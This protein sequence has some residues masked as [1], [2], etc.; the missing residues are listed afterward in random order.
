VDPV[1]VGEVVGED[2]MALEVVE[3]RADTWMAVK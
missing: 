2:S 3:E 1:A